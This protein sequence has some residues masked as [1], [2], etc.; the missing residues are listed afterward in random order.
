MSSFPPSLTRSE[1]ASAGNDILCRNQ[2]QNFDHYL[3]HV[4]FLSCNYICHFKRS[5]DFLLPKSDRKSQRDG[6]FTP[7]GEGFHLPGRF[8]ARAK[9]RRKA[10]FWV[11]RHE[12]ARQSYSAQTS[13][14]P[15]HPVL[16]ELPTAAH[17]F[18][19]KANDP[20]KPCRKACLSESRG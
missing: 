16:E 2:I 15:A 12:S 5:Q 3:G 1:E 8:N 19:A 20:S 6:V 17:S 9:D 18:M 4:T 13:Q 11:T 10:V 14:P 7:A